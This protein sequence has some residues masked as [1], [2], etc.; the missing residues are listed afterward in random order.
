MGNPHG[1]RISTDLEWDGLVVLCAANNYDGIKLADQHMAEELSRLRPV[2]YVDPPLSIITAWTS[3]EA[4]RSLVKPK[5]QYLSDRLARL[6]PV[7]QP[8][9]TRRG[10]TV[11]TNSLLRIL[12]RRAT[13]RLG[14][15]VSAVVSAW[16]LHP[17]FG[18]CR[19][20]TRIYWAQDDFVGGAALLG[21]DAQLLKS[22]ELRVAAKADAI[23]AANPLVN[24]RWREFGS[25]S[26]LIPFGVDTH[27]YRAV[28]KM[29]MPPGIT[30]RRPIAGF[31]GH[32]N[33][34][35]DLALLEEIADRGRS[36]LLVGPRKSTYE[37]ARWDALVARP[38]VVWVGPQPFEALPNYLSSI[39]VG[40][41]PYLDSAFNRGSFPLKT[42][43]YL[44]AGKPVVATG[45][46][47]IRWLNTDLI[48][49]AE[50]PSEFA[51]AVDTQLNRLS[52][53]ADLVSRRLFA[54]QHSWARRAANMLQVIDQ[55]GSGTGAE[56][57]PVG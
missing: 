42:L 28:E 36:L 24:E 53:D 55:I 48:K 20:R 7:V 56:L 2:L 51:D 14:G 3:P 52:T 13:T 37:P 12:L 11:I 16:P 1:G 30:L 33:D 39:D 50:T 44:A 10:M 6:T 54:A 34:R 25:V 21:L 31:I 22:T 40:L 15:T 38:N 46:P 4:A 57:L 29:M 32:I 27:P 35:M 8:F 5:L 49:I 23:V 47:A 17:I 43:E 9:P 26:H 18:S 45:L 19:E 41:V